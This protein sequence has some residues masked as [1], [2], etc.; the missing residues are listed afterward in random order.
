MSPAQTKSPWTFVPS[1]MISGSMYT[2][3]VRAINS[4]TN[5]LTSSISIYAPISEYTTAIVR[6]PASA[7]TAGS[8]GTAV[9]T[10]TASLGTTLTPGALA[11]SNVSTVDLSA[12]TNITFIPENTFAGSSVSTVTL[13]DTV[14]ILSAN[15]FANCTNLTTLNISHVNTIGEAALKGTAISTITITGAAAI[16]DWALSHCSSMI[17]ATF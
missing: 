2:I 12:S 3:Y 11:N 4:S 13:P 15:A 14:S 9:T 6:L 8:I 7:I 10:V 17:R 5:G 1:G 16:A